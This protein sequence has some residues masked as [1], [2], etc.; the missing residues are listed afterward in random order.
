MLRKAKP[1]ADAHDL[2]T[3]EYPVIIDKRRVEDMVVLNVEGIIKL[4]Q[5]AEF[6]AQSLERTLESDEG[7]VLLDLSQINY[8]DSTGIGELVGYLSRFA[9]R[10]RKLIL[11]A[12]SERIRQLL[13]VAQIQHLFPTYD[14]LDSAIEAEKTAGEVV[15]PS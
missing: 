9:E 4:G 11:V 13:Q 15:N 12:P 7:H 6:L 10:A 1:A 2:P 5:S 14:D 3:D 8:I